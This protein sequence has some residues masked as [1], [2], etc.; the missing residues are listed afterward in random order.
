MKKNE[1]DFIANIFVAIV[2]FII[3]GLLIL[4]IG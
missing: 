3:L 2:S 1:E 4:A